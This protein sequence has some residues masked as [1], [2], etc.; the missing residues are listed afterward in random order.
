MLRL[1]PAEHRSA[2]GEELLGLLLDLDGERDRPSPRQ[3]IGLLG[4]ALRL[5]LFPAGSLLLA[6]WLV[7]DSTSAATSIYQLSTGAV[8]VTFDGFSPLHNAAASVLIYTLPQLGTAVAWILGARRT[9]LAMFAASVATQILPSGLAGL[10]LHDLMILAVL[11][12][13]VLWRWPAPRPR[14][15][16]LAATALAIPLWILVATYSQHGISYDTGNPDL[17]LAPALAAAAL[18][19]AT[20]GLLTRHRRRPTVI[21]IMAIGALSGATLPTIVPR[22]LYYSTNGWLLCVT[23]F[24]AL[25]GAAAS[26]PAGRHANSVN[27][28]DPHTTATT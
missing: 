10:A 25:I 6:A 16:L 20:A 2:R 12:P 27:Q 4:L 17:T 5:R 15:V 22:L 13:A 3:T 8:D 24:I 9:A 14:I 26:T 1:L 7:A 18:G 21:T 19:A 23:A 28:P 11:T